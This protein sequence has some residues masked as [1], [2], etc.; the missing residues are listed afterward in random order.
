[1]LVSAGGGRSARALLAAALE[2]RPLSRLRERALAAG[3]AAAICRRRV[4][5]ARRRPAAGWSLERQR[6]DFPALLA[7]SLLSVSQAGYNTVVEGLRLG[8]PM[9]LVP[10]ETATETEQRTR[11]SGWRLWASPR[12]CGRAS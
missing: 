2:A 1:M 9:V 5:G 7:K 8:K 3:R 12:S 4:A 11:R 10:F 6:D